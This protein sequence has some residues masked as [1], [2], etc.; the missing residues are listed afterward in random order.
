MLN[1]KI[2]NLDETVIKALNYFI[3]ER[4][5]K[6]NFKRSQLKLVIGSVNA[7]NT[8]KL[9]FADFPVIFADETNLIKTLENFKTIINKKIIDEAIVISASGEKDA[10]WEIKACKDLKIKTTL[11]T[12]NLKASSI[13]LADKAIVFNKIAE[14]YS[15]NFSTYISMLLAY[16]QEDPKQIK[17]YLLN[18]KTP[19]NFKNYSYYSFILPNKW[20]AV[21]DMIKVKDDEMFAAKSKI[22]AFSEG[23]ARHAKFIYQDKNELVI[24][25]AKNKYFGKKENR[26]EINTGNKKEAAFA[27]SLAYFI[28]G[29]I[30]KNK[31]DYFKKSLKDYCLNR[32]PKPYNSKNKFN[33]IVPGNN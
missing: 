11:L 14:P 31:T 9:I 32:G 2:E 13:K 10:I 25:F 33:I 18:L 4:P 26:W 27:L 19:K 8:A 16:F 5:K 6:L 15:Y 20:R 29:L 24:S 3:K 1:N 30:Q 17:N 22:R 12:C 7:Y 28:V 23:Q 21:A